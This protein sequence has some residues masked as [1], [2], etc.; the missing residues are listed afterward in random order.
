MRRMSECPKCHGS[1]VISTVPA[2]IPNC[3]RCF[4]KGKILDVIIDAVGIKRVIKIMRAS[5]LFDNFS[6]A[7]QQRYAE[8]II[9]A[10]LDTE[11]RCK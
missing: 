7:E 4:G 5:R 8:R 1:G 9:R 10:Y 11:G 3:P 2:G 6:E